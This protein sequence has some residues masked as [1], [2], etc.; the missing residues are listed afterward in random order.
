MASIMAAGQV[1]QSVD[2]VAQF[3]GK[4]APTGK[5][6]DLETCG[7]P[8]GAGSPAKATPRFQPMIETAYHAVRS[9][10]WTALPHA[11]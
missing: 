9:F 3:A 8:V 11:P 10:D 1:F 6:Q 4:P 7:I 5:A 2:R